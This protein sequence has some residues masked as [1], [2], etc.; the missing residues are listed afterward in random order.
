VQY[1]RRHSSLLPPSEHNRRQRSLA[2]RKE[3]LFGSLLLVADYMYTLSKHLHY[4][5]RAVIF[6]KITSSLF[7][8]NF[9][10]MGE[11]ESTLWPTSVTN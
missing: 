3:L 4:V 10:G 2:L 1:T 9:R 6:L 7:A 11:I 5:A 8:L